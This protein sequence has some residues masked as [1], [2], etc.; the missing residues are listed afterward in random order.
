MPE[1]QWPR[2]VTP[3]PRSGQRLRMPGCH[4]AGMAE[5]SYPA[6][7]ARSC[8]WEELP[9]F[10]GQGWAEESTPRLKPGAVA[11]RSNPISKEWWLHQR[12]SV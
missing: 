12:S 9:R 4:S 1:G 8:S 6:S 10:R 7:E 3:R 11:G 5:G 2:G